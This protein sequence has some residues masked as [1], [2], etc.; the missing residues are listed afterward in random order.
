MTEQTYY[1]PGLIF[2]SKHANLDVPIRDPKYHTYPDGTREQIRPY[3]HANFGEGSGNN[4]MSAEITRDPETGKALPRVEVYGMENPYSFEGAIADIRGG[5]LMLDEFV[6]RLGLDDDERE[7]TARKLLQC[8][9]DPQVPEV[10]LWEP[11]P[12]Q[13]PMSLSAEQYAELGPSRVVA[14]ASELKQIGETLV[15]ERQNLNRE[16][17]VRS[18][19]RKLA[20]QAEAQRADEALTAA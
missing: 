10:T 19:E 13:P 17:I 8:A 12:A 20:D 15:Y 1:R 14:L 5:V 11:A 18:L 6:E 4:L 16:E 9:A 7:A 3:I 2:L